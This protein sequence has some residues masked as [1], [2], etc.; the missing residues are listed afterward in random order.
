M[1]LK[2]MP[3]LAGLVML[4]VAA[5]V[6][7]QG[8]TGQKTNLTPQQQ[9]RLEEIR[10]N[11]VQQV[12]TLLTPE[13]QQQFQNALASGQK[14]RSAVGSLNLSSEQQT[15]VQ[16]VMQSEKAQKNALLNSN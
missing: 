3:M 11:S 6:A 8:C 15:Q 5:P 1:K 13:Q 9:S 7:A 12:E 10:R 4:S 2:L 14:M 16:Q